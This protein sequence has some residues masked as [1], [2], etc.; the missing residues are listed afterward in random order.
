MEKCLDDSCDANH[1]PGCGAHKAGW[2]TEGLCSECQEAINQE[3]AAYA[4][5]VPTIKKYEQ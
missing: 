4:R 3:T 1:C 2:Y 5:A